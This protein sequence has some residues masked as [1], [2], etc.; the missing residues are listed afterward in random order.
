MM[1]DPKLAEWNARHSHSTALIP[2]PSAVL[3]DNRHLL[4]AQ[5]KA[6]DLACGFAGNGVVLA[7]TGLQTYAWDFSPVVIEKLNTLLAERVPT[8]R[9]LPLYP[10]VRD[11]IRQPPP[12]LSFDVIVVSRFLERRLSSALIDALKPGGLLFYQT[13]VKARVDAGGPDC[14]DFLLDE[15]ELLQMFVPP[16]ILHVYREEGRLG[17]IRQGLRNQAILVA[18]KKQNQAAPGDD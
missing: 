14:A 2:A 15:N 12:A 3:A 9:S 13:F 16:L 8:Q 7:E 17:D 18:Q 1:P 6:L 4:P 11:V 5:G 10:Q